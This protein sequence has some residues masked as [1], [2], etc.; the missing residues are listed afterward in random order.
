MILAITLALLKFLRE[1]K[2]EGGW[3]ANEE[4]I[5]RMQPRV[6]SRST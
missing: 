4:P 2:R 1:E 5:N 3:Q 6:S